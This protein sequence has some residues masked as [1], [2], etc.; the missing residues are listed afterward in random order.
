[1]LADYSLVKFVFLRIIVIVSPDWRVQTLW[2]GTTVL[3]LCEQ[4]QERL[5]G[6]HF[7]SL[8]SQNT[9]CPK[10]FAPSLV[11]KARMVKE[12]SPQTVWVHWPPW[13]TPNFQM[14]QS[15]QPP[16]P[17]LGISEALHLSSAHPSCPSGWGPGQRWATVPGHT[18]LWSR[19]RG[20]EPQVW[21]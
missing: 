11:N 8:H 7:I 3:F 13:W 15:P 9:P 2:M 6:D 12:I 5:W 10:Y 16:S 4:I 1:M 18:C 19:C 14:H 20:S 21:C 17:V